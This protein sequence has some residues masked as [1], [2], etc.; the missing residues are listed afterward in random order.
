[1]RCDA[2]FSSINSVYILCVLYELKAPLAD[3]ILSRGHS[4]DFHHIKL[5]STLSLRHAG[6]FPGWVVIDV[7]L[8]RER[9]KIPKVVEQY[10]DDSNPRFVVALFKRR[11]G[12]RGCASPLPYEI[13]LTSHLPYENFASLPP[14]LST[15]IIT[16]F[17]W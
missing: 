12:H 4:D 5:N 16:L 17:L 1:M 11:G 9:N 14:P 8:W 6:S 15:F 13:S 2:I 3:D 10:A 7:L